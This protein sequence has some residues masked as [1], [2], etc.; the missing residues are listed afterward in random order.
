MLRRPRLTSGDTIIEVLLAVTIFSLLATVTLTLM[1]QSVNAAQRAVEITLVRQEIDAQADMLRVLHEAAAK[2]KTPQDTMWASIAERAENATGNPASTNGGCPTAG[3]MRNESFALT[4][5][6]PLKVIDSGEDTQ[7]DL[8]GTNSATPPYAQV[9]EVDPDLGKY[10]AYGIWIEPS[11]EGIDRVN[12]AAQAKVGAYVFRIRACWD[13]PGLSTPMQLETIV[14]L[15]D[16]LDDQD[17]SGADQADPDDDLIAVPKVLS[18]SQ[19]LMCQSQNPVESNSNPTGN[20]LFANP[21]TTYACN[22]PDASIYSC[23]NYDTIYNP[24]ISEGEGGTYKVEVEYE[25]ALCGT[26]QRDSIPTSVPYKYA[27]TACIGS[28]SSCAWQTVSIDAPLNQGA[29]GVAVFSIT[30]QPG[31]NLGIRWSNNQ[32]FDGNLSHDP[33]FKIKSITLTKVDG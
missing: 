22:T 26:G 12:N 3:D 1:N 19:A 32:F 7:Y 23:T 17:F 31:D 28:Q 25:D 14:K 24:A 29:G 8:A 33:D 15:Y 18:G 16:V 20:A 21:N 5:S 10:M 9:M 13:G 27:L 30:L 4:P 6:D 11:T 2:S